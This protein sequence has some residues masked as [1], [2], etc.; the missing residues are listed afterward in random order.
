MNKLH[1]GREW[2]AMTWISLTLE[3]PR[4]PITADRDKSDWRLIWEAKVMA[5]TGWINTILTGTLGHLSDAGQAQIQDF[6]K[7]PGKCLLQGHEEMKI[8]WAKNTFVYEVWSH[9]QLKLNI[10]HT[11]GPHFT[12]KKN[13]CPF[14]KPL[15]R[16]PEPRPDTW[17]FKPC[18]GCA[19]PKVSSHFEILISFKHDSSVMVINYLSFYCPQRE[20]TWND[21]SML[22]KVP[23]YFC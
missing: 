20:V 22:D 19:Q 10:F 17:K 6:V 18:T 23:K 11:E 5:Q 21:I 9:R 14:Q 8:E 3:T 4:G 13:Q 7:D 15:L 2:I 16:L 1:Q 12:E